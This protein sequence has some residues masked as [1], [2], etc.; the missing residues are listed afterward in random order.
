MH[1]W[2]W[3]RLKGIDRLILREARLQAHY[4]V[5]W[6]AR[7]ARAY[8]APRPDDGHT[9]LGWDDGLPGFVAQ[10]LP[11]GRVLGLNMATLALHLSDDPGKASA[12]SIGLGGRGDADIRAWL[13]E[14]LAACGLDARALEAPLPYQLPDHP[15]GHGAAYATAGLG[16]ALAE[17]VAWYAN[18]DGILGE[19]RRRIAARGIAAPPVRCWPHHFDL[20]SLI[21]LAPAPR[22]VG[23]GF[24]A[25]DEYYEQPYFYVSA[26]PPPDVTTLPALPSVGHWHVHHFT[27]ALATADR[28]MA[29]ADPRAATAAFVQAAA[30]ILLGRS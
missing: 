10:P 20:D 29:A 19:A 24:S 21:A 17:L 7:A 16:E 18:A 3:Q 4:A 27:A 23:L 8:V 11:R 6:L 5:Q 13:G 12:R 2:Q 15:L 26:Y 28:L 22:T 25:G 1:A 14:K 9:N 30:D